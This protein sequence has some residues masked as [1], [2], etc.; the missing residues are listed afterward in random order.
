MVVVYLGPSEDL[1]TGS[2]GSLIKILAKVRVEWPEG[3]T[4]ER[5]YTSVVLAGSG[6]VANQRPIIGQSNRLIL[7]TFLI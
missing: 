6:V 7:T 3:F 2:V 4:S 1:R 5:Q